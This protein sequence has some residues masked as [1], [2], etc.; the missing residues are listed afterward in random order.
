MEEKKTYGAD[1]EHSRTQAF[2]LGV[3]VV[4][5]T[6]F[7]ALEYTEIAE[8]YDQA[9][10]DELDE[11]LGDA[12]LSSLQM[13]EDM[14][15]LPLPEK[16]PQPTKLNIVEEPPTAEAE[17]PTDTDGDQGEG[18]EED[19]LLDEE[20]LPTEEED[21]SNGLDEEVWEELPEFPGGAGALMKWLTRNINYPKPAQQQ[22]IQGKVVAQ[23]IVNKDGT[24]AD[25][26]IVKSLHPLCDNEALRVL[27]MMPR[28]KAG[29]QHDKPC[30]T[31]VALPI[32]FK[33]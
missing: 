16:P 10:L 24:I 23:F 15:P 3:V 9:E 31:M 1:L 28:W 29:K 4:L 14:A 12:E 18:E 22:K 27:R 2:L 11:L 32:V 5:A 13:P 8:D 6:L 21:E 33:L 7:V 26:Q 25:I 20:P 30:T 19:E 17:E